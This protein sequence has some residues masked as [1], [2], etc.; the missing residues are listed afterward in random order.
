MLVFVKNTRERGD[1]DLSSAWPGDYCCSKC[2]APFP[3]RFVYNLFRRLTTGGPDNSQRA[4]PKRIKRGRATRSWYR[5]LRYGRA[6]N[7]VPR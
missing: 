6:A 1:L 3:R 4:R 5:A 7:Q 2:R